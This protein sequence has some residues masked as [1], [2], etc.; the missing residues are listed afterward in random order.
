MKS[1]PAVPTPIFG[2]LRHV[3]RERRQIVV[4]TADLPVGT[5]I[6]LERLR[7]GTPV[8]VMTDVRDGEAW[9]AVLQVD[10]VRPSGLREPRAT[11]GPRMSG[12]DRG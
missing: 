4:G 3:D 1:R 5:D 8:E 6:P 10:S 11:G 9:V 2:S 7:A 12:G